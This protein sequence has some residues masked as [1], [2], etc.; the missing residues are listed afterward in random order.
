M[1]E[2]FARRFFPNQEVLG[3]RIRQHNE[4][5]E[6]V[7]VVG[8][9]KYLGLTMDTDLAYYM[10]LAQMPA[11]RMCLVVRS[12]GNAS[13][14]AAP[15]RRE[16]QSIDP[17]ITLA[18]MTTM[19]KTLDRSV[20]SP[21]FNTILLTSF[22]AIAFVLAAVG[23]YGLVA[24][25]VAQ[26]SHEIGVRMALGASPAEVMSMIFR[27]SA[28]FAAVG[29]L[30]GLAGA[31]AVTHLLKTMLF[32]V[33][34]TDSISFAGALLGVVLMVFVASLVPV[35]RARRISPVVALRCE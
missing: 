4:W 5:M 29:L 6:I 3:K 16:I 27:Q 10:P 7:G 26:R 30:I 24:Y 34:V 18:E 17:G 8:N 15:L 14:L 11:Q 9:V 28:T 31:S 19:D 2:G 21:R 12:A 22:A 25:W 13:E 23:I 33:G 35:F 20:S 1:S 32:G